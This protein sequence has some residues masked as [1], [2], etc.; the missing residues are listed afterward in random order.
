MQNVVQRDCQA[1]KYVQTRSPHARLK[2]KIFQNVHFEVIRVNKNEQSAHSDFKVFWRIKQGCVL[3]RKSVVTRP[4]VDELFLGSIPM[5][6]FP[7][8]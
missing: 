8:S 4:R 5:L 3:L 6:Y 1:G 2:I 7:H